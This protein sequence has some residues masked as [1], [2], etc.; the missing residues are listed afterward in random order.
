MVE[1]DFPTNRHRRTLAAV[2][3]SVCALGT[4]TIADEPRFYSVGDG[5][6]YVYETGGA[7]LGVRLV[8]ETEHPEGGARITHVV[9]GSPAAEADLREGDVVIE[10]DGEVIRGPVALTRRIRAHEPDDRVKVKVLRGGGRHTLE[11]TLG[12][13]SGE[14]EFFPRVEWQNQ[15]EDTLRERMEGLGE[16]LGRDRAY[17]IIPAPDAEESFAV[18]FLYDWGKPKLGVQLV[19]TT[20]ELREHLGGAEDAGVLV[21]KVLAGT[22]AERAGIRVGDLILAVD[23]KSVADVAELR[24]ALEG[25]EGEKFAV[26]L[27]RDGRSVTVE[28]TIPEPQTDRPTGPRAGLLPAPPPRPAPRPSMTPPPAPPAPV[29]PPSP[30]AAPGPPRPAPPPPAAPAPTV[31]NRVRE[32]GSTTTP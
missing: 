18:P 17:S 6:A 13:R 30:A 22:P 1:L 5:D 10:F 16:R 14:S 15:L 24:R 3:V 25:K 4:V 32:T 12:S 19:E 20:P 28:V 31:R 21:S 23:G 26:D 2:I 29:P 27:V 9:K 11:V 8:E 7:Y